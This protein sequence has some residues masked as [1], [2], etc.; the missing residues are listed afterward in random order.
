M[1]RKRWTI[2][3]NLRLAA[4]DEGLSINIY[5]YRAIFDPPAFSVRQQPPGT[6]QVDFDAFWSKYFMDGRPKGLVTL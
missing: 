4:A 1:E 6:K 5:Q 3:P 2:Q